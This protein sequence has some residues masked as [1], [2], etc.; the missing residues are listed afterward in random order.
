MIRGRLVENWPRPAKDNPNGAADKPPWKAE[1]SDGCSM[2]SDH[3]DT[4]HCCVA[5]DR[6]YYEAVG[7]E[8]GRRKA[9]R[10]FLE[11]MKASG[12]TWRARLRWLGVRVAGKEYWN[13]A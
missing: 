3:P 4:L 5:H 10:V 7:G 11:C 8:S 9:D 2:V 13:S 6:A 12:W 1:F